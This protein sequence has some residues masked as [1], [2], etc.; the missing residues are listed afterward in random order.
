IREDHTGEGEAVNAIV[1]INLN[2]DDN[3]TILISGNNFYSSPRLSPDGNRL[4]WLTWNHPNMPWDGSELWIGE[5][6]EDGLLTAT[7]RVGGVVDDSVLQPEW[8]PD[9]VLFF[10]SDRSGWWNLFRLGRADA[11]E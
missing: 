1:S 3:G 9:V 5:F 10:V 8:S 4:A 7:E 2:G 6:T 11:I